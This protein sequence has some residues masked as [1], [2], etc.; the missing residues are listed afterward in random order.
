MVRQ[1]RIRDLQ[2]TLDL[3]RP[4]HENLHI[5]RRLEALSN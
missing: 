3:S 4:D 5:E 2:Q 1:A